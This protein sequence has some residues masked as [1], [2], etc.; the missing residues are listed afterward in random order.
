MVE[1]D[2]EAEEVLVHFDGWS[3]RYDEFVHIRADRLRRLSQEQIERLER[4]KQEKAL[5]S[6]V[7]IRIY[8]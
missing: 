4:E 2:A 8:V 1:K 3:S 5:K 6:K 7:S